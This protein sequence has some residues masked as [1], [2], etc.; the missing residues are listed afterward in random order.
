MKNEKKSLGAKL[1]TLRESY[2]FSQSQV[3][4]ALNIDRSTYTNYELDKT[5]PS[6]ETLVKLAHI[7]NVPKVQLLPEEE[8]VSVTFRDLLRSDSMLQ[9]LSKEERGLIACYR[10]LDSE[11]KSKLCE[12]MVKLVK[13]P[14]EP[15]PEE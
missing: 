12:E 8:G 6:L 10:S 9:T 7:F 2:N 11:R 5:S 14:T 4:E 15:D 3:A 13:Q 1:R